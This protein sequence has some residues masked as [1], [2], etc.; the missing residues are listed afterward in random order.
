M[1]DDNAQLL[2]QMTGGTS[3]SVGGTS[4]GS[5]QVFHLLILIYILNYFPVATIQF[6]SF[7][8]DGLQN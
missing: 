2:K 3:G 6:W 8:V 4:V 5:Q 1:D 7:P